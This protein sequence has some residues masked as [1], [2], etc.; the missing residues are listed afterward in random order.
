[1]KSLLVPL[2]LMAFLLSFRIVPGF[3]EWLYDALALRLDLSPAQLFTLS[4]IQFALAFLVTLPQ[5]VTYLVAH[6]RKEQMPVVR[7]VGGGLCIAM[8]AFLMLITL[9][10]A[11]RMHEVVLTAIEEVA[12]ADDGKLFEAGSIEDGWYT[13]RQVGIAMKVPVHWRWNS[14]NTMYRQA[15]AQM[16]AS[17]RPEDIAQ[18]PPG[19]YPL[20]RF[21]LPGSS[22]RTNLAALAL[23]AFDKRS[24]ASIG[25]TSL[26]QWATTFVEPSATLE[27]PR[28]PT[29]QRVGSM[30]VFHIERT[31]VSGSITNRHQIF[32]FETENLF[33]NLNGA[34]HEV[35]HLQV[36]REAVATLRRAP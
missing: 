10:G 5:V 21:E 19:M 12:G 33:L 11:I 8:A 9:V 29:R 15:A 6:R 23:V 26:E 17:A 28:P 18:K 35:E 34:T 27:P 4:P 3:W 14:L 32:V 20:F 16:P 22:T 2:L 1:M 30:D 36:I 24:F 25:I 13:N 31:V 7:H